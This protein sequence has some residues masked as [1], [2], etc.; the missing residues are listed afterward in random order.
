MGKFTLLGL[1]A[2][3]CVCAIAAFA[4]FAARGDGGSGYPVR[5]ALAP[6]TPS[7]QPEGSAPEAVPNLEPSAVVF[8]TKE[9]DQQVAV[10]SSSAVSAPGSGL[11]LQNIEFD[12][13]ESRHG[14]KGAT[15]S[16]ISVTKKLV[17]DGADAGTARILVGPGSQILVSSRDLEPVAGRVGSLEGDPAFLSFDQLRDRGLRVRYDPLRDVIEIIS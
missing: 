4:A 11:R 5:I 14:R 17:V 3:S 12:L 15:G 7:T 13:R 16:E 6:A 8:E 2:A 10:A 1:L 9:T